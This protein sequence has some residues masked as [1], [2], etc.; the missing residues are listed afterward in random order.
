MSDDL[1]TAMSDFVVQNAAT[2]LIQSI[3]LA[4]AKGSTAWMLKTLSDLQNKIRAYWWRKISINKNI[5]IR[6]IISKE[7]NLDIRKCL[8][9]SFSISSTFFRTCHCT[10]YYYSHNVKWIISVT[11]LYYY[12]IIIMYHDLNC[13]ETCHLSVCIAGTPYLLI[14]HLCV[15]HL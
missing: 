9:S 15:T 11:V 7:N 4:N 10:L 2:L 6:F 12:I 3:I 14:T 5:F 8:M 1:S 13:S